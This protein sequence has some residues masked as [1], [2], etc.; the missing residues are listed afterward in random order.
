MLLNNLEL[1][2]HQSITNH[3][4]CTITLYRTNDLLVFRVPIPLSALINFNVLQHTFSDDC[5]A[6]KKWP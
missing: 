5:V 6:L 4:T 2:R 1:R 3:E